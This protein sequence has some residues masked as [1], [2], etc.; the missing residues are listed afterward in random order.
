MTPEKVQSSLS[1]EVKIDDL[2]LCIVP[3][4]NTEIL[5]YEV[6]ANMDGEEFLIYLDA[7]D[8]KEV[9]ILKIIDDQMGYTV[10]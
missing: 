8:G 10:M 2:T 5:C 9:E 4:K 1:Q 6:K 3:D 7:T